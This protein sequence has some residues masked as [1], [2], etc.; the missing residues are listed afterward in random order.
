M[1]EQSSSIK[2]GVDMELIQQLVN[3]LGVEPSQAE[4]GL[5]L[6]LNYAKN[7]L[8]ADD[9]SRVI[10]VIPETSQLMENVPQKGGIMGTLGKLVSGLGGQVGGLGQ[11]SAL[12]GGFSS[13]E[14]DKEMVGSFA[15]ITCAFVQKRGGSGVQEILE[16]IMDFDN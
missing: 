11:L 2:S 9:F 12:A 6:L 4:G 14:M 3:Q 15:K 13:L 5:G 1:R 16:K 10:N 8:T 7:N